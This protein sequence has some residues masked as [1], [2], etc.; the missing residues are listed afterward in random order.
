MF[1]RLLGRCGTIKIIDEF[2]E[3]GE[4]YFYIKN[5]FVILYNEKRYYTHFIIGNRNNDEKIITNVTMSDLVDAYKKCTIISD[6]FLNYKD[7]L[8]QEDRSNV[9][10][11][12]LPIYDLL[13][14]FYNHFVDFINSGEQ[15]DGDTII[16]F[17]K[18]I[19]IN[20][21]SSL[22]RTGYG[23]IYCHGSLVEKGTQYGET[24]NYPII[25]YMIE[26]YN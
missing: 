22:N 23:N 5:S 3:S 10:K 26:C 11:L 8:T 2:K 20:A 18:P 25:G 13:T 9:P 1:E 7:R 16:L 15:Y 12:S 6:K 24:G 14:I 19:S 21:Q 4:D 17:D